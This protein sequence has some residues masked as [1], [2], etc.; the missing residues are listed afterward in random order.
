[1]EQL[2]FRT[3]ETYLKYAKYA[4]RERETE[5]IFLKSQPIPI[6][7]LQFNININRSHSAPFQILNNSYLYGSL[8]KFTHIKIQII[9]LLFLL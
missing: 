6:D 5:T 3:L 4:E 7:P 8:Q 9:H 1:M 2:N